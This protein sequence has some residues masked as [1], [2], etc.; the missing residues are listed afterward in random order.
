ML[1]I[2]L[3]HVWHLICITDVVSMAVVIVLLP[4]CINPRWESHPRTHDCACLR[5]GYLCSTSAVFRRS[6]GVLTRDTLVIEIAGCCDL[7][8]QIG[9]P[10]LVRCGMHGCIVIRAL[11]FKAWVQV[12]VRLVNTVKAS[13]DDTLVLE[14]RLSAIALECLIDGVL[15]WL[16]LSSEQAN[17]S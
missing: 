5:L 12:G 2:S 7:H 13:L 14:K 10:L 16:L 8:L 15:T 1:L 17:R 9:L 6:I 3:T 11:W 4:R